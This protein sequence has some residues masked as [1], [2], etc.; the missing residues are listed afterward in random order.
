MWL[1][2][3]TLMS[4]LPT[5]QGKADFGVCQPINIAAYLYCF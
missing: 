1:K 2:N 4:E 3:D 5:F